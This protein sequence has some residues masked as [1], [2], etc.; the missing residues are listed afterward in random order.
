[1]PRFWAIGG[2]VLALTLA[3]GSTF[4]LGAAEGPLPKRTTI[5][6]PVRSSFESS[7]RTMLTPFQSRQAIAAGVLDRDVKSM[8][9]V[10]HVMRHGEFVWNDANV[11]DGP[12]WI[13]V[14]LDRQLIS[15]FRAGHEIG[16]AVTLYGANEK[17]TP[18]GRF[19]VQWKRKDHHSSL[20][21]APM[22]YTLRLTD[23]GIAIHGSQV[24]AGRATHGCIG[25]PTEFARRLFANMK[26]GDEV[27]ILG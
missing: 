5:V 11:P 15:I 27:V 10:N 18:A 3:A 7:V 17:A 20:Y 22:P 8:L 26:V 21:D 19:K 23:D 2:A 25:V 6:E 16:T 4:A 9:K 13:R 1:M 12:T 14:D 24:L